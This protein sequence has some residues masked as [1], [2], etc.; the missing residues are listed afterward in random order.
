M[1][2]GT[3][4]IGYGMHVNSFILDEG[5]LIKACTLHVCGLLHMIRLNMTNMRRMMLFQGK[6]I[7]F[8]F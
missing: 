5:S 6:T 8:C 4:A 3:W 2:R 1:A 7:L